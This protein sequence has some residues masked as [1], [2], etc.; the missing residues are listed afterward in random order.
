MQV[1]LLL[2]TFYLKSGLHA[3]ST[4]SEQ[5]SNF[6]TVRFLKNKY[7]PNFGFRTSLTSTTQLQT[8]PLRHFVG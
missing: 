8:Y 2:F 4:G 7:E 3:V 6:W 1:K 5:M